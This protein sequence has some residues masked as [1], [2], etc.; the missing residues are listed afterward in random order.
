MYAFDL[1]SGWSPINSSLTKNKCYFR[2]IF[3]FFDMAASTS[4]GAATLETQHRDVIHDSQ[5][6]YYGRF[7]AT[8]SSDA[9]VKVF[10]LAHDA[11]RQ[12]Q[13]QTLV[14]DL[15]G[16]SGPVWMV[17]WAPP[18]FGSVLASCSYDGK[19]VIWR[20]SAAAPVPQQQQQQPQRAQT[21]WGAVHVIAGTHTGSVNA[22]AW[23]P[24]CLKA[25]ASIPANANPLAASD[26][27]AP[28]GATVASAGSDGN[29]LLTSFVG[30]VWRSSVSVAKGEA[31]HPTGAMAVSFAPFGSN[32]AAATTSPVTLLAS[33]GCDGAVR[34][35]YT[36]GNA[37]ADWS[38]AV[39]FVGDHKDWVRDVAFCPDESSHWLTLASCGEDK[40]VVVRRTQRAALD[41]AC[42]AARK[43]ETEGASG[44]VSGIQWESA[45][46]LTFA[47]PVWRLSWSPCGTMLLATTA[48][49]QVFLLKPGAT[50]SDEWSR[51]PVQ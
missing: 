4:T 7:L 27:I 16:H 6:D 32:P 43:A 44:D 21:Y 51:V 49:S 8:C 45:P 18:T 19:V 40:T 34:V 35:W 10:S 13:Q 12:Q 23:A 11:Q 20:E 50:F 14:A 22:V 26:I 36:V 38:R 25:A 37:A 30:G 41:A 48:D 42:N 3:F 31:A 1:S 15:Q 2:P 17:A 33:G 29:V 5:F 24:T 9:T 28:L 47:A 39:Q 46:A